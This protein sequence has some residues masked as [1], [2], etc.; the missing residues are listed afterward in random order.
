MIISPKNQNSISAVTAQLFDIILKMPIKER[1]ELLEQLKAQRDKRTRKFGRKDYLMCVEFT[2]KGAFYTGFINNI[3]SGGVFIECLPDHA[4]R[5]A[6]GDPILL[7]FNHPDKQLHI[8]ISG[9][10]VRVNDNGVGVSFDKLLQDL[11]IPE[12]VTAKEPV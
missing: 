7:T 1:R 6:K 8:K 5:M 10:I 3:S 2:V 4:R 11:I 9:E 12:E